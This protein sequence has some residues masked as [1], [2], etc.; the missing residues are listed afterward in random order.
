M[1]IARAST[2]ESQCLQ[3]L[4]FIRTE[5]HPYPAAAIHTRHLN[6]VCAHMFRLETSGCIPSAC[7]LINDQGCTDPTREL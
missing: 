4:S 1:H 3:P 6:I 2:S 5:A 7:G